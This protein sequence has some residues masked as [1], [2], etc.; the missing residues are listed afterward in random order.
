M[1]QNSNSSDLDPALRAWLSPFVGEVSLVR[2]LVG[3]ITGQML[4][5]RRADGRG[6]VVVRRWSGDGS[7]QH[8]MVRR[9]AA[10]LD[11]LADAGLPIPSLLAA[12]PEGAASGLP[13][14]LT[15]FLPGQVELAPFDLRA[16]V[17]RLAAMLAR[18]HAVPPPVLGPCELW[19]SSELSW[20]EQG[21]DPGLA[22]TA[23]ELAA[24]PADPARAVLSHGDYQHFNVLWQGGS[25]SAVVDWPTV[26]LADRGLDVGHCRL[27]LAVLFSADA[28]MWFLDDY[29]ELAGVRV[30]PAC[31]LQRLLNFG[32]NWPEFIPLQV[33]GRAPVDGPGMAGRVRETITRTLR[34]AD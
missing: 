5:V 15:R 6:D 7:W 8:D 11:A 23:R 24:R 28:A 32:P 3:G 19:A 31:D 12:D 17:R 26:G 16:W 4:Q 27:N 14:T 34:R 33:A 21:G 13:T 29:E 2:S 22:R 9:E 25:I 20:L 10:G 18:I 30:D 1:P